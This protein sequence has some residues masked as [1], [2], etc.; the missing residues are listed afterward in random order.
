MSLL[1]E[2]P[3]DPHPLWVFQENAIELLRESL[4]T[5]HKHPILQLPTG[6]GK[7]RIA[8]EL[9]KG[10]AKKGKKAIFVI[11]RKSLIDQ[12][13]AAFQREG[14]TDLGVIQGNHERT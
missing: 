5:G 9:V 11:P 10:A 14:V 3:F 2:T 7:T 6:S 13:V 1:F 12:T 4:R 8:V